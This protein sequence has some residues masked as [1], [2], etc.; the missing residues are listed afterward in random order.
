MRILLELSRPKK[1]NTGFCLILLFPGTCPEEI[2]MAAFWSQLTRGETWERVQ[3][4]ACSAVRVSVR[5]GVGG[6]LRARVLK[7]GAGE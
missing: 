7:P 5:M 4:E 3:T 6:R 2:T 1:L